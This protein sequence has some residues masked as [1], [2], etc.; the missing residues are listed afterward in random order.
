MYYFR[1][2]ESD[3][4]KRTEAKLQNLLRSLKNYNYLSQEDYKQIYPKSSRPGLF[5]GTAKVHKLKEN[6]IVQNLSLGSII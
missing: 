6:G 3:P 1:G 5:Y 2:L 4:T